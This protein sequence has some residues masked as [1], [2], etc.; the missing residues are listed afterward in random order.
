VKPILA[1]LSEVGGIT[2]LVHITGGGFIDNIPR[3]LPEN[4]AVKLDL[5]AIPVLPVFG[6][7]AAAG[8]IPEREMLR[9]FNCGI[10]MAI[11]VE[12]DRADA[13][14]ARLLAEGETVVRL[15]V[16]LARGS[17]EEQVLTNGHLSL[18]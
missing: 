7:L 6:W 11:I 12:A 14:Q 10:G 13:V 4:V 1:A 18:A 17:A 8:G 2:G 16:T 9:T 5:A 15:G 3:V